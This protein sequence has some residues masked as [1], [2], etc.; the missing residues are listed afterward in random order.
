MTK[1][2]MVLALAGCQ[3]KEPKNQPP[4]GAGGS[5]AAMTGDYA[6]DIEALCDVIARSGAGSDDATMVTTATWL[7]Q[8]LKTKQ[9]RQ[10]LITIQPLQGEAKASALDAEAKRA[11]LADC[12]LAA[13]WRQPPIAN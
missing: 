10:F 2:I 1:W 9:A 6:K 8:N 12:K 11:G 3:G 7:A 13:V 4:G 5:Q